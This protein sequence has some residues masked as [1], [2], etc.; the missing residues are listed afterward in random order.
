MPEPRCG[1]TEL[2]VNMCA[3]CR[4]QWLPEPEPP[5][6]FLAQYPGRCVDCDGPI[7]PGDEI[8]ATDDGYVCCTRRHDA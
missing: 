6:W 8:A 5:R 2:P 3:H 7:E 1:L 4:E